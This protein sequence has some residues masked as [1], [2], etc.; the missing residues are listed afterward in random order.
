MSSGCDTVKV[1]D[2]SVND[3]IGALVHSLNAHGY[4]TGSTTH[5]E[6]LTIE[7]GVSRGPRVQY[8]QQTKA[9]HITFFYHHISINIINKYIINNTTLFDNLL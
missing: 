7:K 3:S 4:S 5:I 1:G 8:K 9:T 6:Q 2:S